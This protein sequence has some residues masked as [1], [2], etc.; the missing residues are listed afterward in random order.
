MGNIFSIGTVL[1]YLTLLNLTVLKNT[2]LFKG[3]PKLLG[4]ALKHLTLVKGTV[5]KHPSFLK[6]LFSNIKHLLK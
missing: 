4:S 6:E 2:L 5:F 1:K 3:I